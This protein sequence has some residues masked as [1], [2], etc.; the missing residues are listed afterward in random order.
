MS[1]PVIDQIKLSR[2]QKVLEYLQG[3]IGSRSTEQ[4]AH[5]TAIN[6]NTLRNDLNEL[7]R[8]GRIIAR[9]GDAKK[10]E[11]VNSYYWSANVNCS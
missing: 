5:H 8:N 2:R 3:C 9:R 1:E 11:A 10:N 7:R 4:I 6:K